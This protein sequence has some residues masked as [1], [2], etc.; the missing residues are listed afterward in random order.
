MRV[1]RLQWLVVLF[2]V[3]WLPVLA[4]ADDVREGLTQSPVQEGSN[5]APCSAWELDGSDK[6][7]VDTAKVE[8]DP[9]YA[10]TCQ[11]EWTPV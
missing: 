9:A 1:V 8:P 2:V 7:K 6:D 10:S 3:V 11:P 5:V 4:Q